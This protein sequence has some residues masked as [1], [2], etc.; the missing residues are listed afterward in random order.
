MITIKNILVP[1][2]FSEAATYAARYAAALAQDRQARLYVLHVKAPFPV[3]GRIAG[4]AMEHVQKQR[5]QKEQNK[6]S[7]LIPDRVKNSIA[8]EELQV[9][10]LPMARVIVEKARELSV[11]VIVMPAQRPTGWL[12]FFKENA[13]QRVIQNAPCSV[14]AVRGPQKKGTLENNSQS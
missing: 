3:H 1:V 13:M 12:R 11:D 6:L 7:G 2:D 5:I 4:G 10:G 8:I 14:Y 9:T